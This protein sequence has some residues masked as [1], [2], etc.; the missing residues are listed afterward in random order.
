VKKEKDGEDKEYECDC[1][2]GFT[3]DDCEVLEIGKVLFIFLI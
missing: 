3:G 1:P 2:L